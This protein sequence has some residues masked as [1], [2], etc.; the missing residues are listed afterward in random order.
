MALIENS[1]GRKEGGGYERLFG[2]TQLGHLLSRVQATVIS[3]GTELEKL[4]TNLSK[5][6]T[7]VDSFLSS[8]ELPHGTYVISKKAIK[9]SSLKTDKEPDIIVFKIDRQ[10]QHCYIIE[11]KDG[12]TFDTKKA[13]GE[14]QLLETFENHLARR[15][16]FTTS[17][18][19]CSFNQLD[20]E[21]I[22]SGFKRKITADMAMTGQELCDL[23]GLDYT[24]IINSRIHQQ[25][26]NLDYF[27]DGLLKIEVVR[28]TIIKKLENPSFVQSQIPYTQ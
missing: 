24:E 21:K 7:D 10:R 28:E 22:V 8:Q 1:K 13:A 14:R 19:I 2:S 16:R 11:L 26:R 18:H 27:I 4:I 25:I 20:K 3:S 17:V 9:G 6:I 23:L 15:I 12:D 5:Q